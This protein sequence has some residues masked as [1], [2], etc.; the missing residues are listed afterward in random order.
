MT[1]LSKVNQEPLGITK[2]QNNISKFLTVAKK[3]RFEEN[4]DTSICITGSKGA[5]KSHLAWNIALNQCKLWNKNFNFGR[6]VIY[7]EDAKETIEKVN[8]LTMYEP[9]WFDESA[10]FILAENWANKHAK[11]L[12]KVFS[13]IRTKKLLLIFVLPFSFKRIDTKYKESLLDY[14]IYVQERDLGLCFQ[15][16]EQAMYSGFNEDFI[17]HKMP[18]FS[19]LDLVHPELRKTNLAMA[20]SVARGIPNFY[21]TIHWNMMPPDVEEEYLKY[22]DDAVYYRYETKESESLEKEQAEKENMK[23]ISE[24]ERKLRKEKLIFINKLRVDGYTLYQI[25]DLLGVSR[26]AVS[27]FLSREKVKGSMK[28]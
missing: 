26:S 14:W 4:R 19:W 8:S 9:L 16:S 2:T 17:G 1:R 21:T 3:L 5:G 11:E 6:N 27:S 28:L 18:Y 25:A 10:R 15:K 13:E 7:T 24:A 20:E 23:R 12:K 22:R